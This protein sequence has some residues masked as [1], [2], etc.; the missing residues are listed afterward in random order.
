[1]NRPVFA[2]NVDYVVMEY[3]SGEYIKLINSYNEL[4]EYHI[5]HLE[6]LDLQYTLFFFY[7]AENIDCGYPLEL[8]Q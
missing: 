5:L 3:E 2:L 1:M 6:M 4:Q 7:F 8:P